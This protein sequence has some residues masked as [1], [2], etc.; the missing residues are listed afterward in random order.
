MKNIKKWKFF[1][2]AIAI[3]AMISMSLTSCDFDDE[4]WD[5]GTL[6]IRNDTFGLDEVIIRVIIRQGSSSGNVIRDETVSIRSGENKSYRLA[7]GT[8][9]VMVRTDLYF[10]YNQT[11]NI[12]SGTTRTLTY[13]N[14]GLW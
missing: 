13:D 8:Y 1:C 7:S 4:Y 10:E 9:A 14:S 11:V 12:T 2:L 5:D 3:I 6:I